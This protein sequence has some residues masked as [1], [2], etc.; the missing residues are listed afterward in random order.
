MTLVFFMRKKE[1]QIITIS[2]GFL[3]INNQDEKSNNFKLPCN[4]IKFFETKFNEIIFYANN[5][6]RFS[7]KL[8]GI[9]SDKKRWE[10]KELLRQHVPE[11]K[12]HRNILT[13]E[14]YNV[15]A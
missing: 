2:D 14:Q 6:E 4:E 12:H 3:F 10:I 13:E 1:H 9:K 15:L 5:N 8:D 11:N 7:V